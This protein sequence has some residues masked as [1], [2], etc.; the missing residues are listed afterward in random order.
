MVSQT[1]ESEALTADALRRPAD[2]VQRQVAGETFLVPIRGR[3]ADLQELFVLNDVGS[4]IWDRLD[5]RT[6]LDTLV[7]SV[8]AE[9]DVDEPQARR[10]TEGFL[11]KLRE[12]GLLEGLP[13]L[14][15]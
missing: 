11:N 8:V 9:F 14:E 13:P 5:G 10:D 2:V 4:W 7:A 15:Y 3:L 6:S 12:A 1:Q